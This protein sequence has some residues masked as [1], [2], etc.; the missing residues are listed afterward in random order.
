MSEAGR[1]LPDSAPVL[2]SVD[3]PLTEL[4]RDEVTQVVEAGLGRFLQTVELEESLKD[5]QFEG[6][7]IVRFHRPE[8]WRGVGL[9]VGDVV[10]RINDAPIERPEQAY[11]VFVSLKT[12]SALEVAYLRDGRPMR[13]SL[14]IVGPS[15]APDTSQRERGPRATGPSRGAAPIG[16]DKAGVADPPQAPLE[17]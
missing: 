16:D 2:E 7:R 3:M 13:L 8:Q 10:T 12:A 17:K 6:F 11:A 5:G 14:P 9:L 4:T 15:P 1:E